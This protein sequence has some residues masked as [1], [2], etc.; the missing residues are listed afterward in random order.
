MNRRSNPFSFLVLCCLLMFSTLGYAK[1][2]SEQ[3]TYFNK[4]KKHTGTLIFDESL[5]G[6]RPGILIAPE[7]WGITEHELEAARRLAGQGYTVLVMDLYGE[8]IKTDDI[9][10]A[11]KLMKAAQSD[12]T[13]MNENF[14]RALTRLKGHVS[15]DSHRIAAI[16]FGFGGGYL[17]E[18]ARWGKD[19]K[20]VINFY[21]GLRAPGVPPKPVVAE[22]LILVGETDFYV[23]KD[24]VESFKSEMKS[25]NVKNQVVVFPGVDHDFANRLADKIGTKE[26]LPFTFNAEATQKAWAHTDLF[27]KRVLGKSRQ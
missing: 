14:D 18:Q 4:D 23:D 11:N 22:F 1:L 7:W 5:K 2:H 15:V 19:I 9:T 16:G 3:L 10:Q 6:K 12:G 8:A 24:E 13:H 25:L 26:H 27:L 20:G 17:L 21:G